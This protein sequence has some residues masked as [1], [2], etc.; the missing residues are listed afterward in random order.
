MNTT[1]TT[2]KTKT[3]TKA[4][5]WAKKQTAKKAT[6]K[7]IKAPT[8]PSKLTA[9]EWGFLKTLLSMT[10]TAAT[11]GGVQV[12]EINTPTTKEPVVFIVGR[13]SQVYA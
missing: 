11:K 13:K 5:A 8:T 12:I 9:Y 6:N 10:Y 3:K 4:A 7:A 1:T 2:A